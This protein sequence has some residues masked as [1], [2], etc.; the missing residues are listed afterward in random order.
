M[1]QYDTS[2]FA[3]LLSER[4]NDQLS[5]G[6]VTGQLLART[7][8]RLPMAWLVDGRGNVWSVSVEAAQLFSPSGG[9]DPVL[10]A[11]IE[12]G[13]IHLEQHAGTITITLNTARTAPIT[14]AGAI[15]IIA[16]QN[17]I[18][19]II[20]DGSIEGTVAVSYTV[21]EAC[22]MLEDLVNSASLEDA[23]LLPSRISPA[24]V[25]TEEN[26]LARAAITL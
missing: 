2:H 10:Q 15:Y 14:L 26:Q 21:I 9:S 19:T 23:D 17:P 1:R 12:L 5:V 11:V 25:F 8:G 18:R 13:F 24:E 22:R 16:D 6:N 3:K 20:L 7:L 4:Y